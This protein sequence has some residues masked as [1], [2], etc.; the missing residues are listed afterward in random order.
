LTV[1]IQAKYLA[2]DIET[3]TI[4]PDVASDWL[5]H[6]PLGI[7]CA[8]TLANDETSPRVWHGKTAEGSP[9]G[10]M[11]QHEAAQL[12]EYLARMTSDGYRILT[13]N[14]LAFDFNILAEESAKRDVCR[15]L[16]WDHVDM[17]FHVFCMQGFRVALD[18][19][20]QGMGLPG[21]TEGMSGILAPQLWA[22]GR[23]QE[24]LDYVGQDVRVTL[25]LAQKCQQSRRF[26]WV[27]Q[28]GTRQSLD[29]TDGWLPAKAAYLLPKPDTSWMR[30]P[31]SR[32]EFI[33]WL[34]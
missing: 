14:G 30:N 13:W 10:R 19:A 1:P 11:Q 25:S 9:A 31:A 4:L 24:V 18:K 27:T 8:A 22:E 7:S 5:R 29:L 17:M 2:F 15:R 16:A 32:D 6:R 26:R 34:R 20:A 12:V 33:A 3:A 21:K 23:H 28:K